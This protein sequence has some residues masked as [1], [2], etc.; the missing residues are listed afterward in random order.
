MISVDQNL[1]AIIIRK[2]RISHEIASVNLR[3][4][5]IKR[6]NTE[7]NV[8]VVKKHS[9]FGV[10]SGRSA[11]GRPL[12]DKI[13][14]WLGQQPSGLDEKTVNLDRIGDT[15]GQNPSLTAVLLWQLAKRSYG[16]LV[17]I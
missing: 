1:N 7:I 6:A 17:R 15:H 3:G 4:V 2:A 13:S 9:H 10:L 14:R 16:S 8:L 12:L 11:F 5:R